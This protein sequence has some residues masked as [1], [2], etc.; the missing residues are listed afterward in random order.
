MELSDESSKQ[1]LD[2]TDYRLNFIRQ[3]QTC[4]IQLIV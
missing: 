2:N 4:L 3:H 1:K